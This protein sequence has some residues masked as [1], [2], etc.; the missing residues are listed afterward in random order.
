MLK[1]EWYLINLLTRKL[2]INISINLF[3]ISC[4]MC[5]TLPLDSFDQLRSWIKND[6]IKGLSKRSQVLIL[7]FEIFKSLNNLF[8]QQFELKQSLQTFG[9]ILAGQRIKLAQESKIF[10]AFASGA[11]PRFLSKNNLLPWSQG[12]LLGR[13]N[14]RIGRMWSRTLHVFLLVR[15]WH[16]Y[17]L[18][19]SLCDDSSH[20]MDWGC[21]QVCLYRLLHIL[22]HN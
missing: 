5:E 1:Y 22:T 12:R 6:D 7:N 14:V 8:W 18:F 21:S 11:K 13:P 17:L 15:N 10:W 16:F 19:A 9:P 2:I 3:Q 4:R 20:W